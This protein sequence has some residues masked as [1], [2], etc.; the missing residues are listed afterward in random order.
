MSM[1]TFARP[2]VPTSPTPTPQNHAPANKCVHA[3][4][5]R[6][7]KGMCGALFLMS[8]GPGPILKTRE[9]ARAA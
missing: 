7:M 9:P 8:W 1:Y 2:S 6:T 5:P 3:L 4:V